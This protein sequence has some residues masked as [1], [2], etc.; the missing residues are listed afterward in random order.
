MNNITYHNIRKFRVIFIMEAD[1]NK[2]E[3]KSSETKYQKLV[4]T[5]QT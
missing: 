1:R 4:L 3:S 2:R 5:L